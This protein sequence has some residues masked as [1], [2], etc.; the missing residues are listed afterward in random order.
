MG[1]C[2]RVVGPGSRPKT[3]DR[4]DR[5]PGP[6]RAP[7]RLILAVLVAMVGISQ[8]VGLAADPAVDPTALVAGLGPRVM[9]DGSVGSGASVFEGG[10]NATGQSTAFRRAKD[11]MRVWR[12]ADGVPR[13]HDHPQDLSGLGQS[14]I[15]SVL[16][17]DADFWTGPTFDGSVSLGSADFA[18]HVVE[19]P[20]SGSDDH[21]DSYVDK[22][23]P[24]FCGPGA[25]AALIHEWRKSYV[26]GFGAG[27]YEEPDYAGHQVR[28]YWKNNTTGNYRL[29]S[30]I[31]YLAEA[32]SPT[33]WPTPGMVSFSKNSNKDVWDASTG[34][35]ELQGGINYEIAA[36][37]SGWQDWYYVYHSKS[38]LTKSLLMQHVQQ[39]IGFDDVAVV[40]NVHSGR[41]LGWSVDVPHSIAILGFNDTTDKYFYVDTCGTSCSYGHNTNGY[42][43][44][45]DAADLW[46]GLMG[47]VY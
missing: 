39:D 6:R 16:L 18:T 23:Y 37:K 38:A 21:G 17:P 29:R 41:A 46:A 14:G 8:S 40:F 26:E 15:A 33:A 31:M 19:P 34:T 42:G 20:S 36:G 44:W 10:R 22:Y 7:V 32:V 25:A 13:V 30:Y 5:P 35:D 11:D 43:R 3:G 2:G 24:N 45:A 27:S 28:T 1:R 12:D 47:A 4:R 9:A